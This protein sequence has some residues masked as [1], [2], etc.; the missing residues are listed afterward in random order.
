MLCA[1]PSARAIAALLAIS[2]L[3]TPA[4]IN[5]ADEAMRVQYVGIAYDRVDGTVLYRE[6]HFVERAA[7][8]SGTRLVVYRCPEGSIYGRKSVRYRDANGAPDFE[9]ED[10]RVPF[11]EA[12][13]RTDDGRRAIAVDDRRRG[14]R[15]GKVDSGDDLVVDAG[16]DDYV[17]RNWERLAAGEAVPMRFVI[18]AEVDAMAFTLTKK[19]DVDVEGEP[20]M[21]FRLALGSWLRFVA[22]AIDVTYFVGARQL[23]RFDGITNQ[24]DGDNRNIAA[25]IEFPL[26]QRMPLDA[27]AREAAATAPLVDRC[28]AIDAGSR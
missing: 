23:A 26:G 1:I 15:E 8:G 9:F 16:F 10:A 22:P 5:A 19:A 24:R 20:A 4:A 2:A 7:D 11:T 25:R 6:E 27:A 28:A 14:A 21:T 3:V 13:T 12:V 17:K 18:P